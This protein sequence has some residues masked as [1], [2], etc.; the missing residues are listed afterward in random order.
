LSN[1]SQLKNKRVTR[2]RQLVYDCVIDRKDHP[3]AN[4]VF[5]DLQNTGIGIATVY[6]QL[7]AMVDKGILKS[8]EH[9]GQIRYDPLV[10]PHAH[11]V[12]SICDEIWDVDLPE[13][14]FL[15]TPDFSNVEIE[16]LELTWKGVCESCK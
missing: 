4:D 10:A 9:S 13:D 5:A 6:R 1:M 8:F 11:F 2:Q 16:G 14:I 12:C 15:M 7:S 3:S